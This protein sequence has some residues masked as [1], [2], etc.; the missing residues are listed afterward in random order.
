MKSFGDILGANLD[1]DPS[2]CCQGITLEI[3]NMPLRSVLDQI[4]VQL[5]CHWELRAGDPT[6]LSIWP[7]P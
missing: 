6:T 1:L 2:L 5:E 7:G 4:C 3:E